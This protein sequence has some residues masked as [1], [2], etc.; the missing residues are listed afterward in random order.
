MPDRQ[1]HSQVHWLRHSLPLSFRF[2]L[3]R[4]RSLLTSFAFR[5]AAAHRACPISAAGVEPLGVCDE[6][7]G[8]KTAVRSATIQSNQDG[9]SVV[10]ILS[11]APLTGTDQSSTNFTLLLAQLRRR[12]AQVCVSRMG[13][14]TETFNF[15]GRR[16]PA[17]DLSRVTKLTWD[18]SLIE[19][20]RAC[21]VV[22]Q[23]NAFRL[24]QISNSTI[25]CFKFDFK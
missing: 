13:E 22:I 4:K 23:V 25:N 15:H 11:T 5:Q 17:R 20:K 6:T 12:L 21:V 8:R 7:Q 14:Q 3:A 2:L 19:R 9:P 10:D 24:Y 1:R 18:A 16:R